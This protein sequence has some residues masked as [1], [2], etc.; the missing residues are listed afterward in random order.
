VDRHLQRLGLFHYFDVIKAKDDV[1]Q[2]KPEPELFL[3]ALSALQLQPD[4]ALIFEDSLNGVLAAKKAGI[5]VVA[6]PNP[7]TR[8][9]DTSAANL[10][11]HSLTDLPLGDL[12]SHFSGNETDKK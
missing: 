5:R 12:L 9:L 7:V 8:H 4:Q 10:V 3:A 2:I 1:R 6:V 11:L